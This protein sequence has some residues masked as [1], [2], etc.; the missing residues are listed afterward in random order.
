MHMKRMKKVLMTMGLVGVLA[1]AAHAEAWK[2]GVISDTQQ[3]VSGG[4]NSVATPI[5]A[6][7]N[8]RFIGAGVDLVVQVGDLGDNGSNASM[9]SRAAA[10]ANLTAAGISFYPLRGNHDVSATNYATAFPNLPGTPGGGGSSPAGYAGLDYSFVYNNTKFMLLDYN[11]GVET[12]TVQNWMSSELSAADHEQAFVFSHTN[13]VGQNHK[14]NL[15]GSGNDSDPATQNIFF[16]TLATNNVKY[17]ISGHDHMNHRAIVTSPDG[18]NKVQEIITQSD[19]TKFYAASSGF[20]TREQSISDQQN[21]IG[22]YLFTVD[23]PRVTGEYWAT[24]VVNNTVGSNPVWTLEDTFGYSLNGKQFTI[25]RGA[26]YTN[27]AD[28]ITAGDGFRG[29]SMRILNG[30][31]SLTGTAEG[32][33]AEVDDLNTGWSPRVD[34]LAS[35]VLTLWGMNNALGSKVTDAYALSMNFATSEGV[36]AD[37]IFLATRDA[38]GNWINAFNGNTGGTPNFILG[39]YDPSYGLGTYGLDLSNS[40][41]W[42][43]VNYAGDFSVVPEPATLTLMGLGGLVSLLRRRRA[44]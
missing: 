40:T 15:F 34:G 31:N 20:T 11:D 18:Q 6:A 10:N 14:D 35:D 4:E 24:P 28:Q 44:K 25:A 21:M 12:S 39:A 30:T 3:T 29:T 2:F 5:I 9:T 42:A 33:R 41:A 32:S 43:V 23:G 27:V 16:N 26:T 19:S 37:D 13:L 17:A 7:V 36:E 1:G 22:Y 38:N 8:Q